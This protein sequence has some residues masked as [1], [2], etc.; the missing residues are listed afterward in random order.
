MTVLTKQEI[1]ETERADE[2]D[3]RAYAAGLSWGEYTAR[4]EDRHAG[5]VRLRGSRDPVAIYDAMYE[6][7][8]SLIGAYRWMAARAD[9]EAEKTRWREALQA[10]TRQRQ[11]LGPF[12]E[13]G[14]RA[15][16]V[17]FLA[18]DQA[19]TWMDLR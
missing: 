17:A 14:Q 5:Q 13:D 10:V 7:G 4:V 16:T 3:A 11:A 12:D 8:T 6:A 9:S 18:R 15:T 1:T 19:M 2:A